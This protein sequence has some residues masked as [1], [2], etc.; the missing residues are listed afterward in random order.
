MLNCVFLNN[1]STRYAADFQTAH[2]PDLTIAL[3]K[4]V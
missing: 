2:T 4:V 3:A 1:N